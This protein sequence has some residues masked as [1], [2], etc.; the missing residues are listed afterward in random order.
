MSDSATRSRRG[1]GRRNAALAVAGAAISIV[2]LWIVARDV[3]L[4]R[5]AQIVAGANVGLL[6]LVLGLIP[7]QVVL[8][9]A[10]WRL[11]LPGR[12]D[13]SRPEL[14]RVLPVLLVGYL[15]NVVMPA[16]L[17]E[18]IRGALLARR[19]GVAPAESFGSVV[20]ERIVDVLTLAVLGTVAAI[21]VAAPGWMLT[22]A[23]AA[24][25]LAAVGLAVAGAAGI[26][27][28]RRGAWHL[29]GPLG[30]VGA[31]ARVAR[32]LAAGARIADRPSALL[33]AAALSLVAWFLD[34]ALFW[35]VARSLD[36]PLVPAGAMLVS[37][38]AVLSTAIPTAPGYVG[39]FELAAVAAIGV[40][41]VSGDAA[42]AFAVLAHVLAVIP[43]S[44]AGAL[45][46][47]AMGGRSLRDLAAAR[48]P[49]TLP[50]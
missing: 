48:P 31:V 19:E 11:L 12:A 35:L 8:R 38:I 4:A 33:A 49:A 29:P 16:R 32:Q 6:A 25:L 28:Q 13:G 45:A 15:G 41:G 9:A 3:D 27:A 10:R 23:L 30:R 24:V 21:A 50:T 20:L 7:V 26:A 2:A 46:L 43:I 34:A 37:A 1:V 5:T 36:L 22:A 40:A 47:W 44:L 42:L 14:T 39:T 17:G 18:V